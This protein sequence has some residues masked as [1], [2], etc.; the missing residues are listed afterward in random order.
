MLLAMA[1]IVRF[2]LPWQNVDNTFLIGDLHPSFFFNF[3]QWVFRCPD[4]PILVTF[5][6]IHC[7]YE[8]INDLRQSL[9]LSTH[10]ENTG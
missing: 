9:C 1:K 5:A 10:V 8:T 6:K 4:N 2:E 7:F 3:R